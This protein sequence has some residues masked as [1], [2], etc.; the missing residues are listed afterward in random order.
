M[1]PPAVEVADIFRA[2]T[3]QFLDRHH[4]S[5]QQ[6]KV[7]RAITGCRTA[8]LGGHID[9][10]TGCGKEWGPSYN[11]CRDRHC[12]KCQAQARQ[13]W[14]AARQRELLPIPYFHV[15]FTLPHKL[16]T[17]IRANPEEL[18][19]LLFRTVA[20]TLME[21]AANPKRLGSQIG[22]FAILHTWTQTLVF[23]PHIHCVIPAGGL[24]PDHTR[25]MHAGEGF[26]L[27]RRVLR[28]VFRGKFV[29]GLRHAVAQDR[30]R[31][32]PELQSLRDPKRFRAWIRG[33]HLHPWVVY[34][35]APFGGPEQVLRYLGRYTHRVAISNHRLV[36]FDQNEVQFRWRDRKAGNMQRLMQ[37]SA[38]EFTR[39]FLSHVL[40]K[41]FVRI[42]YFGFMAN[43][44]RKASLALCRQ[45]LGWVPPWTEDTDSTT[46]GTW[47][48]PDCQA[49]M[50]VLKRLT[51]I[52]I[53]FRE[54]FR[55]CTAFDTS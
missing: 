53:A 44:R 19:N 42:R 10:C 7:I 15:V 30:L 45:L 3:A 52:E 24:D 46:E 14:L 29:H 1:M 37:L 39:R 36:S 54:R 16:N 18:Y 33:L 50:K 12:P 5:F 31:F 51:A 26:F 13:R 4:A 35:K 17:L 28:S 48:C 43:F 8:K 25:W 34:S 2:V 11:S 32:P 27:P 22:F 55:L 41:R 47:R 49:P 38:E 9:Y 6:L 21:V 40:P 23:H 20:D